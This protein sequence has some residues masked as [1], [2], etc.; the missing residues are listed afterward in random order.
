M[1]VLLHADLRRYGDFIS[2]LI[3][4]HPMTNFNIPHFGFSRRLISPLLEKY[5][6]CYTDLSSM[7]PFVREAQRSYLEF[8][9]Y[10][11]DRILFGSDA[12]IDQPETV[13]S[14]ME[15]FS[16]LIDDQELLTKIFN[17]NYL[18]FHKQ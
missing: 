5:D 4:G 1:S 11:Q 16:S 7:A 15:F 8:I 2:E 14:M 9:R 17:K 13:R 18:K 6:N 10:H 12:F 3:K